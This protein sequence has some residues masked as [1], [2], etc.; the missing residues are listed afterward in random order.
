MNS[1]PKPSP[2]IATRIG[3]SLAMS[4]SL[5]SPGE[6]GARFRRL[7]ISRIL[8]W[9]RE[10]KR[11][12]ARA[13][14]VATIRTKAGNLLRRPVDLGRPWRA[15]RAR[16]WTALVVLGVLLRLA[17]YARGRDFWLDEGSL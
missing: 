7:S 11:A 16:P 4:L 10:R 14:S 15:I 3:L 2:M 1:A 8:G 13:R 9:K 17:D 12:G 6:V 5:R